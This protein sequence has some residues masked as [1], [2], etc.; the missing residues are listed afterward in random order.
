MFPPGNFNDKY[1]KLSGG[2]MSLFATLK[3]KVTIAIAKLTT[4]AKD[5]GKAEIA[6]YVEKALSP[7]TRALIDT[8]IKIQ[9][10]KYTNLDVSKVDQKDVDRLVGDVIAAVVTQNVKGSLTRDD[11]RAAESIIVQVAS[12][13]IQT[14]TGF[15]ISGITTVSELAKVVVVAAVTKKINLDPTLLTGPYATSALNSVLGVVISSKLGV[16]APT[17]KKATAALSE[18]IAETVTDLPKD[19]IESAVAAIKG[20]ADKTTG[21][22]A[23]LQA[24]GSTVGIAVTTEKARVAHAYLA[25]TF[26]SAITTVV[27]KFAT[28]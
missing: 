17:T 15:P 6:E 22:V 16:T 26:G 13:V 4:K 8:A 20:S 24:A 7:T 11:V 14:K 10:A 2:H 21:A 12:A 23:V 5:A 25:D 1:V 19:V 3:L 18:K 9:I 28:K 27:G